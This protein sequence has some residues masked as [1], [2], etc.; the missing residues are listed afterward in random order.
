MPLRLALG[1]V[2]GFVE[3]LHRLRRPQQLPATVP[4]GRIQGNNGVPHPKHTSSWRIIRENHSFGDGLVRPL[5]RMLPRIFRRVRRAVAGRVPALVSSSSSFCKNVLRR[6][7]L[8]SSCL[9]SQRR[10][11]HRAEHV[12]TLQF[13][14]RRGDR[15]MQGGTSSIAHEN[16]HIYDRSGR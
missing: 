15:Q 14:V 16:R 2:I 6:G 8:R 7:P 4:E 10:Q 9:S 5:R 11:W 12:P 13:G 3:R 1:P